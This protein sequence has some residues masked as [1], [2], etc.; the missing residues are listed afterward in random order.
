MFVHDYF[1]WFRLSGIFSASASSI[2]VSILCSK[3]EEISAFNLDKLDYSAQSHTNN[4]LYCLT[5]KHSSSWREDRQPELK[6]RHQCTTIPEKDINN[7]VKE[8]QQLQLHHTHRD[9]D[10]IYNHSGDIVWWMEDLCFGVELIFSSNRIMW[11]LLFPIQSVTISFV[12]D[13]VT[14]TLPCP[15]ILSYL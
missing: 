10:F 14:G 9:N 1:A 12:Q 7:I 8:Q 3:K 4:Q 15:E 2:V 5:M 13:Q 11:L 6:E